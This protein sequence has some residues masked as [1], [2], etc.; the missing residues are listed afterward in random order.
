MPGGLGPLQAG[1]AASPA[2]PSSSPWA[3]GRGG[4][5]A[6]AGSVPVP[7]ASTEEDAAGRG[8]GQC[9]EVQPGATM[10]SPSAAVQTDT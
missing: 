10:E 1:P 6:P 5:L 7:F 2:A 8:G 9:P 4:G 3:R